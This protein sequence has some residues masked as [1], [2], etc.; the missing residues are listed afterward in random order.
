MSLQ[1]SA[2]S[3]PSF[4]T[5]VFGSSFT[6]SPIITLSSVKMTERHS[7]PALDLHLQVALDKANRK[8]SGS[9]DEALFHR[10]LRYDAGSKQAGLLGREWTGKSGR[11]ELSD[12]QIKEGVED[13][14]EGTR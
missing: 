5:K 2:F 9:F 10:L 6:A 14:G 7:G 11:R 4:L 12:S 8:R 3:L 1:S 13:T